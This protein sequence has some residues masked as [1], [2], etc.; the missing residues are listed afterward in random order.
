MLIRRR[1][2]LL[3]CNSCGSKGIHIGCGKLDWTTMEWDCEDC[4]A[5]TAR[6]KKPIEPGPSNEPSGE[7]SVLDNTLASRASLKRHRSSESSSSSDENSDLDVEVEIVSDDDCRTTFAS[8]NC[9]WIASISSLLTK[10]LQTHH[11]HKYR[12]TLPEGDE[13]RGLQEEQELRDLVFLMITYDSKWP[14]MP[15]R[16]L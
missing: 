4:S 13:D 7:I 10:C 5:L 9:C 12:V 11:K 15:K 16:S 3:L 2:E 8:S 1:W 14:K 6:L